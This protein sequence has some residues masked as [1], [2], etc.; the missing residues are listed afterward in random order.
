MISHV[1]ETISGTSTIRAFRVKERF[2]EKMYQL[3]E[4]NIVA[5]LLTKYVMNWFNMRISL[6]SIVV[7]AVV[8]SLCIVLRNSVDPVLIGMTML[9]ITTI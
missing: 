5:N 6:A 9:Y 3:Q 8:F 7:M 2:I 1:A 4:R